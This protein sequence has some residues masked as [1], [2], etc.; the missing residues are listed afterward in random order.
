MNLLSV[1]NFL[2]SVCTCFLDLGGFNCII[3]LACLG[4]INDTLADEVFN[5]IIGLYHESALT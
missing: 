2:I 1:A 5:E 3:E 4:N